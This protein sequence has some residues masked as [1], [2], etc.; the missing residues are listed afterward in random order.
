MSALLALAA[1]VS[2]LHGIVMRGPITPV[3]QVGKPCS[4]P[5]A[6]TV[7]VFTRNGSVAAR[8][9]TGTDGRYS[10]RLEPGFYTV[11]L[12]QQ[13]RIGRGLEPARARVRRGIDA[14]L[15]FDLDTG[16]R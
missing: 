6:G 15:D 11:R 10:V 3:C 16:I 7:L 2:G 4:E 8:T 12:T 13:P 1:L 14:R 5:A 9:R